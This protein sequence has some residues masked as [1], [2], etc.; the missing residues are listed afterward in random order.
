MNLLLRTFLELR[1]FKVSKMKENSL[2]RNCGAASVREKQ[3]TNADLSTDEGQTQQT[4]ALKICYVGKLILSVLKVWRDRRAPY[5]EAKESLKNSHMY[6]ELVG[7]IKSHPHKERVFVYFVL[8]CFSH[9]RLQINYPRI[10]AKKL[11][12]RVTCVKITSDSEVNC[13]NES[14]S[15]QT[16]FRVLHFWSYKT[17]AL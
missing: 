3:S 10:N 9:A 11:L 7:T 16:Y 13:S 5:A 2:N 17:L 1:V 15:F 12:N 4:S 14:W 6:T 8:Q